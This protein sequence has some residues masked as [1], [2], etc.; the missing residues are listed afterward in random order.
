[1]SLNGTNNN[2]A[3]DGESGQEFAC[4]AADLHQQLMQT[5]SHYRSA[6]LSAEAVRS[7]LLNS[8]NRVT[9][10]IRVPVV[11]HVVWHKPDQMLPP[12]QIQSQIDA[13]N[14]DFNCQG[15]DL[16]D[17]PSDWKDRIGNANIS[18][19][20]T[21]R[22][23]QGKPHDGVTYNETSIETFGVKDKNGKWK[24][25][26]RV[27]AED[28]GAVAWNN[29]RFLNI[30]VCDMH[31]LLGY[32]Y[33]HGVKAEWDGVV[34]QWDAFGTLGTKLQEN[35]NLGRTLTH[36]VG[37]Y[38]DLPHTFDRDQG[39]VPDTPRLNVNE[40]NTG[41]PLYPKIS[42]FADKTSNGPDGD[43]FMNYM[44]YC[45]DDTTTM[46]TKGQV[47]I[48]RATLTTFRKTLYGTNFGQQL[49]NKDTSIPPWETS[50]TELAKFMLLDW[51]Q[52]GQTSLVAIMPSLNAPNHIKL[53]LVAD[54]ADPAVEAAYPVLTKVPTQS[55]GNYVYAFA[56]WPF[57]KREG[58]S[59]LEAEKQEKDAL[60]PSI[61]AIRRSSESSLFVEV[62][63]WSAQLDYDEKMRSY[64]TLLP[65][66][67]SPDDW[68]FITADWNPSSKGDTEDLIAI[69][70]SNTVNG[71]VEL[72]ILSG[73][74]VRK[75]RYNS[76]LAHRYTALDEI[77]GPAQFIFTDWNGDGTRDL[78]AIY[79]NQDESAWLVDILAGAADHRDFLLRV[80]ISD[81]TLSTKEEYDFAMTDVSGDGRPDLVAIQKTGVDKARVI[82]LVG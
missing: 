19:F 26:E 71:K 73:A 60:R 38:L 66:S 76:W 12:E 5:S 32:A 82:V 33:H 7:Q 30:W 35:F 65:V 79:K 50:K 78:A 31:K 63:V 17:V 51:N 67:K 44:D 18:F 24:A 75:Q 16:G 72:H 15:K 23:E 11:V 3:N 29:T 53:R 14:R 68:A 52:N 22:D 64:T 46:F 77:T 2:I 8:T 49:M 69:K 13:I 41:K 47:D 20:L 59:E 54:L 81:S 10:H 58:S 43:M 61:L 27:K 4:A 55:V 21:K 28:T 56:R 36:E 62:E 39:Q 25:D 1:M 48:M 9:G 40:N 42:T 6:R 45:D 80:E 37:H 34:I 74:V 70:K 57:E